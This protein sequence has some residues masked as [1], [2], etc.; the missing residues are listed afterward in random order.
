MCEIRNGLG[1]AVAPDWQNGF[2]TAQ[3]WDDGRFK[4]D[5]ATY[6][7]DALFWRDQRYE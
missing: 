7:S 3:V 4:L 2:A 1:Y 6:V 5:L